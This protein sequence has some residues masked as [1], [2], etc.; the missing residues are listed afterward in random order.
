M[1]TP[2]RPDSATTT[3]LNKGTSSMISR[4]TGTFELLTDGPLSAAELARK[5]GINRSTALRLLAELASTGYVERD[6]ATKKFAL[7]PSRFL[8]LVPRQKRQPESPD[9]ITPILGEIRDHTGEATILGV[10]VKHTMVY[11]AYYSTFHAVAVVEQ[12]GTV[13]PMNCSALGKAYL[14]AADPGTVQGLLR[15]MPYGEGTEHAAHSEAELRRRVQQARRDGYALD[16]DETFED[17]RC[18]AIPLHIKGSLVGAV[19]ISGPASRLPESRMR[20][21]GGYLLKKIGD[22]ERLIM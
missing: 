9:T 12:L 15:H 6:D 5:L 22:T 19:G 11:L 1:T 4:I 17:C 14:A 18:V 10:P 21:L 2:I 13:R 16:L 8:G 20:E 7:V 3:G